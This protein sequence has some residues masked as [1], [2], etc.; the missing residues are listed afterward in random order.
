VVVK[1]A[2]EFKEDLRIETRQLPLPMHE[3]AD[4][5]ARAYLAAARQ[6]KHLE[7]GEG[8]FGAT[9]IGRETFSQIARQ[10]GLDSARFLR[11]FDDPAI[12]KQVEADIALARQLGVSGT[13]AMFVNGRFVDGLQGLGTYAALVREELDRADE[14]TKS[15]TPAE[16]LHAA[17]MSDAL[18]PSK[19]PNPVLPEEGTGVSADP[20]ASP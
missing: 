6:G 8:L 13:P 14:L 11:D 5:A 12:G 17:L 18:P 19:F 16:A 7:F 4:A 20:K 2:A 15:G 1:L 10:A 3:G 9:A